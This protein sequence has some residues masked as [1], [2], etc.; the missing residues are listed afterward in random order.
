MERPKNPLKTLKHPQY[1]YGTL[2]TLWKASDTL[3][4][5]IETPV[6]PLE[7]PLKPLKTVWNAPKILVNVL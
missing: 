1:V 6:D 5:A 7:M 2:K 4:N 3:F